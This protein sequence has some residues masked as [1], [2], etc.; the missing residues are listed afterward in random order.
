MNDSLIDVKPGF[1]PQAKHQ[2]KIQSVFL[3]RFLAKTLRINEI[4]MKIFPK[5]CRQSFSVDFKFT[6]KINTRT[7]VV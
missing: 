6:Y 4:A 7:E 3:R 2:N 1:E 5:I